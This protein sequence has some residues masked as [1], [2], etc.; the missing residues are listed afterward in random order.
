MGGKAS[1]GMENGKRGE[2]LEGKGEREG[3][4]R[5]RVESTEKGEGRGVQRRGG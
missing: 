3:E 5:R 1:Q 4:Q 2:R